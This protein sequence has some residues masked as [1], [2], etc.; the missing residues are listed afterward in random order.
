MTELSYFFDSNCLEFQAEVTAIAKL[1]NGLFAASMPR[2]YFAPTGGG[3]DHDEGWIGDAKVIDVQKMENGDVLHILDKE[4]PLGLHQAKIDGDRR[5]RNMQSHTAQHILS[6]AF[7][8][9]YGFATIS[10]S[11]NFDHPSTIDLDTLN[12]SNA[13]L[14][15]VEKLSN[16]IVQKNLLV[17]SYFISE[18]DIS[19]IPF[20]R[21]PKVSG[22]IRVV[23]IEGFDYSACGGTHC[24]RTG[25]VGI[26]KIVKT[27]IQ[28]KKLRVYFLAGLLALDFIEEIY[29]KLQDIAGVLETGWDHADLAISRQIENTSELRLKLEEYRKK[30]IE[31]ETARL[32]VDKIKMNNVNLI[33]KM[34]QDL[35]QV[36]L[37]N[38]VNTIRSENGY[39]VVLGLKSDAKISLVVGCSSDI[40]LDA[41]QL[42]NGLLEKVG[43]SGGGDKSLAQGGAKI[44]HGFL[45]DLAEETSELLIRMK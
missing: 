11:I 33:A 19:S 7:D 38:L 4:I 29:N 44:V 32:R 2:S 24:E 27:E 42:L 31:L 39:V 12:I 18:K 14:D 9:E 3:Q 10:S 8:K 34:Y 35:D 41:S 40:E 37:R 26:I 15:N 20:R 23:E 30:F 1:E 28:N 36:D 21:P 6:N 25:S 17:K 16:K 45:N 43:G 13:E 22:N 5:I